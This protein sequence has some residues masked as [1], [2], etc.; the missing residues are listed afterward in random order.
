MDARGTTSDAALRD[1]Q[2]TAKTHAALGQFAT[3]IYEKG[4]DVEPPVVPN[5]CKSMACRGHDP[6]RKF[7]FEDD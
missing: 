2:K 5:S 7:A 1:L 6:S 4:I 3:H